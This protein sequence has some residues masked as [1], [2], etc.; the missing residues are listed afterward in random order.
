MLFYYIH[1]F[2][3]SV[4]DCYTICGQLISLDRI[5]RFV[6][7]VPRCLP[8]SLSLSYHYT[9]MVHIGSIDISPPLIN[10]SCAWASDLAQ[11]QELYDCPHTGAVTTRTATLNGFPQNSSHTVCF[12]ARTLSLDNLQYFLLGGVCVGFHDIHQLV[13]LLSSSAVFTSG[14]GSNTACHPSP[15]KLSA[16]TYHN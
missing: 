1:Y 4:R 15:T 14:M 7:A 6:Q 16:Q 11:L 3:R 2:R 13:W 9:V 10:S 12:E 8:S 5:S